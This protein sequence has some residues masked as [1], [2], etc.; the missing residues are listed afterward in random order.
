MGEG[1]ADTRGQE[2]PRLLYIGDVPVESTLHGS[3]LLYR[4]LE[5]YPPQKLRIIE[6]F[7]VSQPRHR[8]PAVAY[9]TFR[10]RWTRLINTRFGAPF[11]A[12]ATF[13]AASYVTQ[14]CQVDQRLPAASGFDGCPRFRLDGRQP[15]RARARA[16]VAPDRP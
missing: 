12:L 1:A 15:L 9:R 11:S 8:L 14:R 4:L 10:P 7:N 3:A 6:G 13:A 2:L 16:S 5:G